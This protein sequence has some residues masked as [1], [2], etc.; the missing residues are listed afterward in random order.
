MYFGLL[1]AS[2]DFRAPLMLPNCF[3]FC[4]FFIL[5]HHHHEHVVSTKGGF[6]TASAFLAILMNLATFLFCFF[7]TVIMY[8]TETTQ[9]V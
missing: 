9:V 3:F 5:H 6:S 4:T 7:N 2:K 1:L 8:S